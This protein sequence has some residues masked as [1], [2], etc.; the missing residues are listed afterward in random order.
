VQLILLLLLF[1]EKKYQGK[2]KKTVNILVTSNKGK[3]RVAPKSHVLLTS[4]EYR[5]W[6]RRGSKE[7]VLSGYQ[8]VTVASLSSLFS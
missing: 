3:Q 1:P 2:R 7:L 4:K 5:A 6:S 8:S